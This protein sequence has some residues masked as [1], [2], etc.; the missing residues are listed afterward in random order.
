MSDTVKYILPESELPK[1][2]YKVR[3]YRAFVIRNVIEKRFRGVMSKC[4]KNDLKMIQNNKKIM[5]FK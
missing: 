5:I 3:F 1:S 4:S 2:W